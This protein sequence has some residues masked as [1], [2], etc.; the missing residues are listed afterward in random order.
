[1][2]SRAVDL[3]PHASILADYLA[4]FA[5]EQHDFIR[6]GVAVRRISRRDPI[7]FSLTL[8]VKNSSQTQT[9]GSRGMLETSHC[10]EVIV[11]TGFW[12]PRGANLRVDGAEFLKGYESVPETG[13]SY[14]GQSVV[15]LG[16]G[17][18][19]METAQALQHYTSEVHVFGRE[20]ELPQGGRGVRFAYETHYVGDIRA[21]RATIL[22]TYLLKSLDTFD[23]TAL[24]R[25]TRLVVIPCMGGKR[26]MWAVDKDDCMDEE[27][28]RLHATGAQGL[29]YRLPIL[30]M[31]KSGVVATRVRS[32]MNAHAAHLEDPDWMIEDKAVD[33]FFDDDH[34]D[35]MT[36][37]EKRKAERKHMSDLGIDDSIFAGAFEEL[38]VSSSLLRRDP[39]LV[40][41]LASL[42]AKHGEGGCRKPIDHVIR[43]FGWAMDKSIFDDSVHVDTSH[44]GKYPVI[45]SN[46]SVESTPGLYFAGTLTHSLDFRQSAGGFIH[47]FRYT[48][49]ALFRGLEEKNFGVPWPNTVVG[50]Q[51]G[52]KKSP[53]NVLADIMIKRVN[54]ASG[55]YQMFGFLGDMVVFERQEH[56]LNNSVRSWKARYL[57]EIPLANFHSR[58]LGSP[59]LSW[60]FKYGEGFYG[61]KVLGKNRVGS[62]SMQTAHNS[63]FLHPL[64]QYFDAGKINSS[65]A[66]WITEDIF[67]DWGS[68]LVYSPLTRFIARVL[69]HVSGEEGWRVGRSF[70]EEQDEAD[71]GTDDCKVGIASE[72]NKCNSKNV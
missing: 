52:Y 21:G 42:R 70:S 48:A 13:E 55:P 2:T 51:T 30:S 71:S 28:D 41:Q 6:F 57:E 72:K 37:F 23:F 53:V 16:L 17:N 32:I 67:T 44:K 14:Q 19:A 65:M 54:E 64:L 45:T 50:L 22:D 3:F 29:R 20:R 8:D 26:C 62:R 46:F 5:E 43:C 47:G 12:T 59:R 36:R 15:I 9:K 38:T 63:T 10:G 1:M 40:D 35:E 68:A 7:G 27:C 56:M 69:N 66:F 4:E 34:L 31:L 61:P 25:S 58:M 60:T 49:R 11:A 24:E 18:A 33:D 39:D